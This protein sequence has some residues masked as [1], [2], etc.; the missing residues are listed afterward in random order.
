MRMNLKKFLAVL[1]VVPALASS[2]LAGS[3]LAATYSDFQDYN[4]SHWG[5][6]ALS[7]AVENGLIN[8]Y[9]DN[10]V[11]A[12]GYLTRAEMATI[13]NRAFGAT[14]QADVSAFYDVLPGDWFY[15]EMAKAVRMQTFYGYD[16]L[17]NPNDYITREEAFAVVARA[18]VLEDGDTAV[19]S[20]F[21]DAAD[22]AEWA[23]PSIAAMVGK[24]YV[25]GDNERQLL[26]KNKITRAEFAQVMH[27]I[28]E[29]YITSSN[30]YTGFVSSR[31]LIVN[32]PNVDLYNL[33]IYG[34]LIIGDGAGVGTVQIANVTV[35]GRIVVRGAENVKFSNTTSL[36]GVVV[37]NLNGTVHFQNYQSNALF[38][39]MISK[40]DATFLKDE[41]TEP[42]TTPSTPSPQM[43][44]YTEAHYVQKLD[45]TYELKD[46][47]TYSGSIGKTIYA[48]IR[49]YTG[50]TFDAANGNN[51]AS[52]KVLANG[53][54]KLRMY[55]NRNRH[56]VTLLYGPDV[57]PVSPSEPLVTVL[58]DVMYGAALTGLPE[59][60]FEK[61][62][63]RF[64]GWY[65]GENGTG[66]KIDSSYVFADNRDI[67]LYA[68]WEVYP[69]E[70]T[71]YVQ[72]WRE[73]LD[74]T[75]ALFDTVTHSGVYNE[76]VT[77]ALKSYT[78][79]THDAGVGG[80]VLSGVLP[81]SG[82]LTLK[83]YYKRN[84][85]TIAFDY[86]SGVTAIPPATL[87]TSVTAKYGETVALPIGGFQKAGYVFIGWYRESGLINQVS[88][89]YLFEN[90]QNIIL[91][92]KWVPSTS[93]ANYTVKHYK[94]ELDGS[95]TEE[96]AARDVITYTIGETVTAIAK[97]FTGFAFDNSVPGTVL[98]GVVLSDGSLELKVY[99][100]RLR[101]TITLDYVDGNVEP[102][103]SGD[104]LVLSLSNV[105]Y[106][107]SVDLSL[108]TSFQLTGNLFA[109][110][111]RD[112]NDLT[113]K[114]E[115]PFVF[116]DITDITL[117]ARWILDTPLTYEYR[118]QHYKEDASGNYVLSA[119]DTEIGYDYADVL[120]T[121]VA[122]TWDGY[123]LYAHPDTVASG[124]VKSDH[125]LVLKLYYR[126]K[127]YTVTFFGYDGVQIGLPQTVKH[128]QS[129]AAPADPVKP[130]SMTHTYTFLSWDKAFDAV[131][132]DLS[133]YPIFTEHLKTFTL[134][135]Y[136]DIDLEHQIDDVPYGSTVSAIPVIPYAKVIGYYK[137]S[138]VSPIYT[139]SYVHE[140]GFNWYYLNALNKK[141][142]FTSSVP[143]TSDMDIYLHMKYATLN[144][145]ISQYSQLVSLK[146]PYETGTRLADTFK[147]A[148]VLNKGV[149]N[150]ALAEKDIEAKFLQKLNNRGIVDTDRKIYNQIQA[151]SFQTIFRENFD[152]F[153]KDSAIGA[154]DNDS[155]STYLENLI[156]TSPGQARSMILTALNS[157]PKASIR[158]TLES[159]ITEL[160]TND[161][162]TF[163]NLLTDYID[164]QIAAGEVDTVK[165]LMKGIIADALSDPA[166]IAELRQFIRDTIEDRLGSGDMRA[167]IEAIVRE[168][169]E[170]ASGGLDNMVMQNIREYLMQM[171][172]GKLEDLIRTYA[173][174]SLATDTGEIAV[175][176]RTSIKDELMNNDAEFETLVRDAVSREADLA[177]SALG[178]L[179]RSTV[180]SMLGDSASNPALVDLIRNEIEDQFENSADFNIR[181]EA[182][183]RDELLA[184]TPAQLRAEFKNSLTADDALLSAYYREYLEDNNSV[185][186]A[187]IR[188]KLEDEGIYTPAEIDDIIAHLTDQDREDMIDE[189]IANLGTL[190]P[191]EKETL[192]EEA[193]LY[194]IPDTISEPEKGEFIDEIVSRLMTDPSKRAAVI[195]LIVD[196]LLT[197]DSAID[198]AV[199]LILGDSAKTTDALDVI[200]GYVMANPAVRE[201]AVDSAISFVFTDD[202]ARDAAVDRLID[203]LELDAVY[204]GELI[205]SILIQLVNDAVFR[206]EAIT[207]IVDETMLDPS[208]A[209][210]SLTEQIL[211]GD[212]SLYLD[213]MIDDIFNDP[214][215]R[216]E[217]I[218]DAIGRLTSGGNTA[219]L[220]STITRMV[221]LVL[222]DDNYFDD[223]LAMAVDYMID[224]ANVSLRQTAVVKIIEYLDANPDAKDD[225]IEQVFEGGFNTVITDFIDELK[226][227]D[228]FTVNRDTLV[229]AQAMYARLDALTLEEAKAILPDQLGRFLKG[230]TI[231]RL[232]N[233][234][235]AA[236]LTHLGQA[237]AVVQN[238][239]TAVAYADC[240][241]TVKLNPVDDLLKPLYEEAFDRL[242]PKFDQYYYY[243]A[244]PYIKEIIDMLTPER[245]LHG[246]S[247]EETDTYSGYRIM[248][249]DEMY[250][251]AYK[252]V[253][254]ADDAGVWYL[255]NIPKSEV[256]GI[257]DRLE[258]KIILYYNTF[259][260]LLNEYAANG[261]LPD[262]GD[263]PANIITENPTAEKIYDYLLNFDK[264][265]DVQQ[266]IE[267]NRRFNDAL[268][269]FV[270]SRFN[271]PITQ[272]NYDRIRSLLDIFFRNTEYSI[273][274]LFD[275]A[276]QHSRFDPVR[277]SDDE[278]RF[279]FFG[280][281]V[282]FKRTLE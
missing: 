27:N 206:E 94:E 175:M 38:R 174:A 97:T 213:L 114:V 117:Y 243:S 120:K 24:G 202:T 33:V 241:L 119:A 163:T 42:G 55:Y 72:H 271:K 64:A 15:P 107:Q 79:F 142:V 133:V 180:K 60:G 89:S 87:V 146:V 169:L 265:R 20:R 148:L 8:G 184:Y 199:D 254:L 86:G 267:A 115:T 105:K 49:Q 196:R 166:N 251:L 132:S 156:L 141:E 230:E 179:I 13:I 214:I 70:R 44:S 151:V 96:I 98:S 41:K 9:Q 152:K 62:Y 223:I 222:D 21:I 116:T 121:A 37:N 78:G 161:T 270:N 248:T 92:A 154:I 100:N 165:T 280:N 3:V 194:L 233:E 22:L 208:A 260:S 245:L 68:A 112:L 150:A 162:A 140:I 207:R 281:Y 244:N 274:D 61:Q 282:V 53:T 26:P 28:F 147:D 25:K 278:Y 91:Y 247:L 229:I 234:T 51:T 2:L 273:D 85:N 57:T 221:D 275:E 157:Q 164:D 83:A 279:E 125:S 195:D 176:I 249:F 43:A 246:S 106:G 102:V 137:D 198:D 204:R 168:Q 40:T 19:L 110:W 153:I 58:D 109:G 203:K 217:K 155:I 276:F 191:P 158:P 39:D 90:N 240:F 239:N 219:L 182:E 31:S 69:V 17:L 252:L 35:Y 268:D 59:T 67:T 84:Q 130:A 63:Y 18:L 29:R 66:T 238:D 139:D 190:T 167:E 103:H 134:Y 127:T 46:I 10:T 124:T 23:A 200:L 258:D 215:K 80:T 159:A 104:T 170:N 126:L 259:Q 211:A 266:R 1:L 187:L 32:V 4:G 257:V 224:P 7:A 136:D 210:D 253:V 183:I 16:H 186:E 172:N 75:Y 34:D 71:Y 5:A 178:A 188:E 228:Q 95:Y 201:E 264:F 197:D 177:G 56:D 6:E 226:T 99:Y 131:T 225:I 181:I 144:L 50:F 77:A 218:N 237:I 227:K 189:A 128:G 145:Y 231:N 135:F 272:E 205:D 209:I 149:F 48:T 65:T 138:S 143:I 30:T 171:S 212:Y 185:V 118:I 250:E 14:V 111:Y 123:E 192:I 88:S 160:L 101:K 261:S 81:L 47:F 74:G 232:Y 220:T 129:A 122:K 262:F 45:G 263:L 93:T 193:L 12:E 82:E 76:P 235:R 173:T 242:D 236:Y 256:D 73:N 277:I 108:L 36:G 54:L 11:K 52:G 113:T 269:R 255:E 216:D